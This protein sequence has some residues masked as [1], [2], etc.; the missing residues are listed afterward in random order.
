MVHLQVSNGNLHCVSPNRH[1]VRKDVVMTG[2]ITLRGRVLAIGGLKEKL[3][4]ALRGGIKTVLIP[5]ENEKDL[6]DVPDNVKNGLD[7]IP[8]LLT[9]LLM[10]LI[11]SLRRN[12]QRQVLS[13]PLASSKA[14]KD[15]IA[16]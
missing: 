7:I 11:S 2:E 16:H 5:K 15:V 14:V 12:R 3:L 10:C 13:E 8:I 1:A 6:A 9:K 4:A